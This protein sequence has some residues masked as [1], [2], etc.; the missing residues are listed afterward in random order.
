MEL[1]QG[2]NIIGSTICP[3]CDAV[4]RLLGIRG[5]EYNYVCLDPLSDIYEV[6]KE[7]INNLLAQHSVPVLRSFPFAVMVSGGK[8]EV[9]GGVKEVQIFANKG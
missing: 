5:K 7:E 2:L 4:K 3:Q 1:K 6:Q 8:I 9:V